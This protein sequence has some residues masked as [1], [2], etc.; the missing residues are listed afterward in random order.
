MIKLR[1]P[2]SKGMEKKSCGIYKEQCVM[3]GQ[4]S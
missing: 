2:E 1:Y 4:R 3:G